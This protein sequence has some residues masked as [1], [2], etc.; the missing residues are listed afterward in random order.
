MNNLANYRAVLIA[1]TVMVC[2]PPMTALSKGEPKTFPRADSDLDAFFGS[3]LKPSAAFAQVPANPDDKEWVRR[4]LKLM[5][6]VDQSLRRADRR[7]L[8]KSYSPEEAEYFEKRFMLRANAIDRGDTRDLKELLKTIRWPVISEYGRAADLRAWLIVQHSDDDAAFQ[9]RIL[10]LLAGLAAEGETDPRNYAYLF[11]RVAVNENRAQRYGTQG[12]CVA[13]G[14]W[15]PFALEDPGE[16][17]A[18]RRSVRLGP[19]ESYKKRFACRTTP[20]QHSS[21]HR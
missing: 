10:K 19:L 8:V 13:R 11:D 2:V 21:S 7:S 12:R 5:F 6:D 17:D 3:L 20:G 4:K 9:K 14:R 15:E 18:R 1:M 16:V